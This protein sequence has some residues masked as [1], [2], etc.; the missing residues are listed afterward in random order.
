[1]LG[2][3][4]SAMASAAYSSTI[5][6]RSF[7]RVLSDGTWIGTGKVRNGWFANLASAQIMSC[8]RAFRPRTRATTD[9]KSEGIRA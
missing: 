9:E 1:M 6:G 4:S 8:T 3:L 7:A 5:R 2:A